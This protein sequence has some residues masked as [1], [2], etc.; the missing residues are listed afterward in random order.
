MPDPRASFNALRALSALFFYK[1]LYPALFMV[2]ILLVALYT[3]TVLLVLTFSNWWLLLLVILVP[4]TL[5]LLVAGTIVR[6]L[7]R[8]LIP[9]KLSS[10]EKAKLNAF[11][12]KLL[13]VAERARLPYPV[14][15]FLVAKDVLRGRESKFLSRTIGD[16]RDLM[17]E[18][19]EI[20]GLFKE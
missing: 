6:Y 17:K 12:D 14:L 4:L 5:M 18:F 16:S 2:V 13:G 8:R 15:L 20:Q 3:L 7:L 1:I 10:T 11:T 19:S 9:R